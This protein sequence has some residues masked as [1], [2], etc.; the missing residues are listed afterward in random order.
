MSS[1]KT[2]AGTYSFLVEGDRVIAGGFDGFENLEFLVGV[3]AYVNGITSNSV[4]NP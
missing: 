1:I 3:S 4:S 2:P